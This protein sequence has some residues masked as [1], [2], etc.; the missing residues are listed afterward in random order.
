MT[1]AASARLGS[2]EILSPLGAGG[3][4]RERCDG[5]GIRGWSKARQ[6]STSLRTDRL[7]G[8]TEADREA[9]RLF[10]AEAIESSCSMR[11]TSCPFRR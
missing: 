1:F 3:G 2:Y 8:R 6:F 10:L 9:L 7:K 11:R 5:R 4:K